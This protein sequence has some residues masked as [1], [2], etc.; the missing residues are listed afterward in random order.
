MRTNK[1]AVVTPTFTHEGGQAFAHM[2]PIQ[3]LRRSVLS[4]LLWEDEFYESGQSI[5]ERIAELCAQVPVS[6][7]CALAYEARSKFHLR[8][9]P[10]LLLTQACKYGS[11]NALVS[12]TITETIQRADELAELVAIYWKHN[13]VKPAKSLQDFALSAKHAPLSKQLRLGLAAA[14]LKFTEY[15]FAKYNRK[16]EVKLR[17]VLRLCHAKPE[18]PD[19]AA[20]FKHI[21]EDTLQTPDTWEVALSGGADKKETFERLLAEGKLG[22]LALL[23]NLRNMEQVGCDM[24]QI[25]RA[26]V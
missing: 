7:I 23:R 20:L 19:Q 3:A 5:A 22:Y 16:N 2:T 26:H 13:A 14:F 21:N 9:V 18:S 15:D 11:G 12:K 17:D 1:P 4:C 25:G 24:Q 8:H 10:L 6:A